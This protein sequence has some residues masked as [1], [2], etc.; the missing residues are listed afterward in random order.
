MTDETRPKPLG[1][2][3]EKVTPRD[4]GAPDTGAR[5]TERRSGAGGKIAVA[6]F[7]I[8]ALLG[9]VTNMEVTEGRAKAAEPASSPALASLPT[10][11]GAHQGARAAPGVVAVAK[12]NKPIVL[13]PHAVVHTV[14][15][16]SSGGYSGGG[17]SYSGGSGYTAAAPAA[18]PAAPVATTSGS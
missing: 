5:G 8:A 2:T 12:V 16:A 11:K 15:G 1:R 13:T 6:G 17:S 10:A 9:L 4:Q 7:G 18:A 3:V 14:G